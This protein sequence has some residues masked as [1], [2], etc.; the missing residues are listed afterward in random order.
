MT[1]QSLY[2]ELESQHRLKTSRRISIFEKVKMFFYILA[3]GAS[4]KK[5]QERLQYLREIISR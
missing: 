1:F 2:F 4:N 3:L 5:I